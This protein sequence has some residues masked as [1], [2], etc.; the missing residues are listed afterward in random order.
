M[1]SPTKPVVTAHSTDNN[2]FEELLGSSPKK[3]EANELFNI[4]DRYELK[5]AKD[6]LK[7]SNTSCLLNEFNAFHCSE[8]GYNESQ[9]KVLAN[10]EIVW[11]EKTNSL[12][13]YGMD[14]LHIDLWEVSQVL[15][16]S[17]DLVHTMG[18]LCILLELPPSWKSCQS[19]LFAELN[20]VLKFLRTIE[21]LAIPN[22]V[23]THS[24]THSLTH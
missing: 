23:Q 17:P 14:V 6:Y 21:P 19:Y 20:Q 2:S 4:I 22:K 3:I 5:D 12:H 9:Q 24:L 18:Y 10:A 8:D 7:A 11:D 15:K 13:A 1:S 16:P